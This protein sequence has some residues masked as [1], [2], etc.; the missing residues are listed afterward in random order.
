MILPDQAAHLKRGVRSGVGA[1]TFQ[2]GGL[3][4]DGGKPSGNGIPPVIAALPLP[5]SWRIVLLFDHNLQGVHGVTERKIFQSLPRFS[6]ELAAHL[7]RLT[8][9]QVLPAAVENDLPRFGEGIDMLQDAM[10]TY[11]SEVQGGPYTSRRVGRALAWLKEEGVKGIGQSS[12][13]PTGFAFVSDDA[14]GHEV[15]AGLKRAGLT[16][17]LDIWLTRVRNKGAVIETVGENA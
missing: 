7:C 11:F 9:M 2:S 16:D 10:G 6:P 14:Q 3:I 17:G 5:E 12:W 4:L 8:L 1:G 13:G 15:L